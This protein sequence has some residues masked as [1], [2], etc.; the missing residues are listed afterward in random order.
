MF[1]IPLTRLGPGDL[2]IAISSSGNSPNVVRALDAAA[3]LGVTTVTLTAKQPDNRARASA[4]S[5]STCRC[6]RYGWAESAH[7][8]ILHRWFDQYLDRYGYGAI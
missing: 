8:V 3:G 4:G 5:I 6:D 1:A 7:Q 2:L